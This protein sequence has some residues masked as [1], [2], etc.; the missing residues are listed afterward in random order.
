M[1][2]RLPFQQTQVGCRIEGA[3]WREVSAGGAHSGVRLTR[4]RRPP[5]LYDA[6]VR[7]FGRGLSPSDADALVRALAR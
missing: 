2:E 4:S 3:Q 1:S 7:R 5:W 6:Q